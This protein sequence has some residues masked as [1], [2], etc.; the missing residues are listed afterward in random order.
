MTRPTPR[1]LVWL[2]LVLAALLLIYL[3]SLGNAPVFDDEYLSGG[4]LFRE[5]GSGLEL[6]TRMLSYGSFVW[7]QAVFGAGW[8]KHRLVNLLL[9]VSVIVALW[10]FYRQILMHVQQEPAADGEGT[11]LVP[12]HQS[13]ALGFAIGFFALNPVAVYAVAY[14][15]QR[16]I[17]MATLFAVLSLW[18]FARALAER[19]AWLHGLALAF[20]ALAVMSKEHAILL[21]LAAIPVFIVVSRPS[22]RRLAA[23]SIAS[24]ALVGLT[25]AFLALRFGAILATPFDEYSR[26]YLAQLAAIEPGADR[27]AF[28]LS[29]INQAYLFFHYGLRWFL[30]FAEWMSINLRPPFPVK[31]LTFPHL[32]GVFGYAAVVSGSLFLV[33]RY[34]DWRCL[35]GLSAAIPALLFGTEFA[36][37]WVQDPFVLYRSYLWAIGVPG[38]VFALVHGPSARVVAVIALVTASVLAWQSLDRV[39]SLGSPE[40]AWTD[41]IRKL[42]NDPRSVGRWFPYLNRG[43]TYVET[44][45]FKL[46]MRDFEA[47]AALGDMGMGTF[48]RGALLAAEGR[49]VEAL[50]AFQRAQKEGYSMYNLPFQGGLSLMALNKPLEAYRQ[51]QTAIAMNPPSPTRE[52]ALVHAGRL[53]M[54]V[55]LRDDAVQHLDALV[56]LEPRNREAR[57][58]LGMAYVMKEEYARAQALLDPLV[59]EEPSVRVLYARALANFGLKRKQQALADIEGAMRLAPD[60]PGLR[61]WR[62]KIQAMR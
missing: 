23:I 46:A 31:V 13:P 57:Y 58:L 36:T 30:P 61:Q 16:S 41:A 39:T 35:I 1:E 20:Y 54:Q 33:A 24:L 14:L 9:H 44:N 11:S 4:D 51:F 18:A 22:A 47:S 10:A 19:R 12:Y 40:S 48:N 27:D 53:A 2:P 17:L 21:P 34:R 7:L 50:D 45:Q 37:V 52:L 26:V 32:I 43:T 59:A 42:P 29:I 60:N 15:I 25:A 55:G 5:Y 56:K 6:R 28:M 38:L 49:H 3:P 62:D 8:W